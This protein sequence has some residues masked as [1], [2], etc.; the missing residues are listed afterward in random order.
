MKTTLF[1]IW[2][3]NS[4][5]ISNDNNHYISCAAVYIYIR[6]LRRSWYQSVQLSRKKNSLKWLK[7]K[8]KELNENKK[9][10]RI[11]IEKPK[12]I[13][14]IFSCLIFLIA[15]LFQSIR[16]THDQWRIYIR[17]ISFSWFACLNTFLWTSFIPPAPSY[18]RVLSLNIFV[19]FLDLY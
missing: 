17:D 7:K 18:L 11:Q 19:W 9:K 14:K 6:L 8:K 13:E 3:P 4:V 15:C 2:T 10:R 16:W 1:G 5:S 12:R